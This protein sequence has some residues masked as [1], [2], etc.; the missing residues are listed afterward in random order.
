MSILSINA[1]IEAAA[2]TDIADDEI[3]KA[4]ATAARALV[5][6]VTSGQDP[7]PL[8]RSGN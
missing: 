2:D 4:A 8:N 1:A 6:L 3:V 7:S 5:R